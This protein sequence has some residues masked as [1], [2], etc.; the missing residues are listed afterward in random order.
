MDIHNLEPTLREH[1]FF[2]GLENKHLELLVGCASNVRFDAGEFICRADEPADKFFLIRTGKVAVE[3]NVPQ[4]G[5]MTIQTLDDGDLVGWSWLFPP[6][7]WNFDAR[8]TTLTRAIALDARCLRTKCET[9]YQLGY[10]MMKRFSAIMVERFQAT[11]LQLMDLYASP[12]GK[13]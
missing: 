8:A 5:P 7:T 4:R 6:Y 2:Q 1:P 10:E 11:R 3:I 13:K 9:D 12:D